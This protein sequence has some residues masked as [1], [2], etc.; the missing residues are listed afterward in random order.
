MVVSKQR[1]IVG[2]TL[3]NF[4]WQHVIGTHLGLVKQNLM[5]AILYSLIKFIIITHKQIKSVALFFPFIYLFILCNSNFKHKR[6]SFNNYNKNKGPFNYI[7]LSTK[8]IQTYL[9]VPSKEEYK[10]YSD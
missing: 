4:Y 1:S 7:I 6:I 5:G 2:I 10:R 3:F 9:F 8:L